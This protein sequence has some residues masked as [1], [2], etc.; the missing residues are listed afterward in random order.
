[1]KKSK[2]GQNIQGNWRGRY[3]YKTQ[4]E[5]YGFEAVFVNLD[6][7]VEGNILDTT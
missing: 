7:V 4:G 5:A 2:N 1:M 6:G 3:F